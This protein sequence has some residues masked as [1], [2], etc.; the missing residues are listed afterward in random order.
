MNIRTLGVKTHLR[1]ALGTEPL[2]FVAS[3]ADD[4]ALV[5]ESVHSFLEKPDTQPVYGIFDQ[6]D[7]Q[8]GHAVVHLSTAIS[9]SSVVIR[10]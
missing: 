2:A 9:F 6:A 10:M 3:P 7:Q 5:M 1:E 4:I 8:D